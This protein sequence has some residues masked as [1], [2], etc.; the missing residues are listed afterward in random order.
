MIRTEHF[1]NR[2]RNHQASIKFAVKRLA[3][4]K[5]QI[6]ELLNINPGLHEMDFDFLVDISGLVLAARRSLSYTYPYRYYLFGENKQRY[7][8]FC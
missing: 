8:D 3:E 4:I 7:F 5:A 6:A 1:A 2:Y